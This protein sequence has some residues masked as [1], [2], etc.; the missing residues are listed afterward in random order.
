VHDT[1]LNSGL[2]TLLFAVPVLF[3]LLAGVFHLDEVFVTSRQG[4]RRPRPVS[5][6][7]E[8]G[9]PMLCDPDGRPFR[10]RD[11]RK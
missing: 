3:V 5:G 2:D 11:N 7:D 9:H 10:P 1:V 4:S 6:M 8:N